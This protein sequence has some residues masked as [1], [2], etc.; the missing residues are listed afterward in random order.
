MIEECGELV[1]VAGKRLAYYHDDTHPDGGPPLDDRL[2]DEMADVAAA[3]VFVQRQFGLDK[4]KINGRISEKL[5]RFEAWH[6]LDDNN[7]DSVDTDPAVARVRAFAQEVI[8]RGKT[9]EN[10]LGQ[11]LLELLEGDVS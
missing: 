11:H 2:E 6:E 1:Q 9:S 3:L 8:A 4:T 10:G 5:S 7:A